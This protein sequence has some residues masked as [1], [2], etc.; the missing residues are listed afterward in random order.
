MEDGEEVDLMQ[1]LG[2]KN[3][4]WRQRVEKATA[5]DEGMKTAAYLSA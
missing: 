2:S 4:Q 5:D 3:L 1:L